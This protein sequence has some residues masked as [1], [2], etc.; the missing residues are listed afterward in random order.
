MTPRHILCV[1]LDPVHDVGI[2]IIRNG[3][4]RR[5]HDTVLLSPDLSMENVV[6]KAA[7][8]NFDFVLVSRTL[9]YGVGE[10]LGRFIDL[11]D[12]AGVREHAK[13]IL[14]GKAITPELAAELGFDKG[15]DEHT[16]IDDIIA[17]IEGRVVAAATGDLRRSKK[18]IT[19]GYS[20]KFHDKR[21]DAALEEIVT[22]LLTWGEGKTSPGIERARWREAA[23]KSGG[24][25]AVEALRSYHALCDPVIVEANTRGIL[26]KGVRLFSEEERTALRQLMV[27]RHPHRP[28]AIRHTTDK[29]LVFKFLGSG[30]PVMDIV[31]AKICERW[32]I[33]GYLVINP[34][35]EARYEGLLGGLLTHQNDG[36][37]TSLENIRLMRE[38]LDP[39]TLLTVRAHRGLNTPETVLLAG[40][41]GANMTKIDLVYGSLGAGTDPARLAVD[42]IEAVKLA[43]RYG[44]PFDIPGN[45]ELSGVPAWK[46]LAGLLIN[47]KL[48]ARLGARPIL[49]PLFCLGPHI[50]ING[51]MEKNFIDYNTAKIRALRSIVDCPIW[52][53]EPIAFMT[54][55]EERVQSA[56]ATSYHATLAATLGVDAMTI[57]STDEAYS[58]GP[59]CIAS[60][61]DSIRAVTD[62]LR[63]T[64][65][66]AFQ[67]TAA[68]DDFTE[69]LHKKIA[70]VLD[71]VRESSSL[72]DAISAGLLGDNEDG[73]YPGTFG[74][75][76]TKAQLSAT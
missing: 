5:G 14:G 27:S 45:D 52:P 16:S 71:R 61:I 51:F 39:A 20:Y 32:G 29:P 34:S 60:R 41:A 13:V 66:A 57:A 6:K 63:F 23:L 4:A 1:P 12:A 31:H 15:F 36:T 26:P 35:W 24:A 54:Q 2:K 68:A 48:G 8:G 7:E 25:K 21:I 76:T 47:V 33:D 64:G 72:P 59:I 42:G 70:D 10:L 55:T 49:K 17:Y 74:K 56:N 53:G 44:L 38:Y 9:G 46:T 30:C 22:K 73:A 43:A 3:L 40:E 62:A 28:L 19:A 75:G 69:D 37:I 18:D 58:R 50:V 11:L 65:D 67:P